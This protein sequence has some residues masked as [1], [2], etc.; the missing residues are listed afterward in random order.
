MM[1][2]EGVISPEDSTDKFKANSITILSVQ[3]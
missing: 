1:N 3:K 2:K